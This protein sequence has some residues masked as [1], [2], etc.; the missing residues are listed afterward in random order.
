M[1]APVPADDLTHCYR[2]AGPPIASYMFDAADP[3]GRCDS[4]GYLIDRDRVTPGFSLATAPGEA[5]EDENGL[6][7]PA[8]P[9]DKRRWDAAYTFDN[10]LIVSMFFRRVIERAAS[11]EVRFHPIPKEPKF[12]ACCPLDVIEWDRT[13]VRSF[14]TQCTECGQHSPVVGSGQTIPDIEA[15]DR[16]G[17]YRSDVEFGDGDGRH[18][19]VV[20]GREM[21]RELRDLRG[22]HFT[23]LESA[24]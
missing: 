9:G 22:V 4:C 23:K 24:V 13:I 20:V 12:F 8:K 14:G 21:Q 6:E 2:L 5:V 18:A 1:T 10:R 17:V 7:R 3:T 15:I 19:I 11:T 16:L